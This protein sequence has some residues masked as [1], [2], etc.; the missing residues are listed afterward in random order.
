MRPFGYKGEPLTCLWCGRRFVE[1]HESILVYP[2]TVARVVP[3]VGD[4]ADDGA[5]VR[6][7]VPLVRTGRGV[8]HAQPGEVV[9]QYRVYFDPPRYKAVWRG[10][11]DTPLFDTNQCAARFGRAQAVLGHRLERK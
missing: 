2:G 1:D 11:D 4:A 3:A 8:R 7:V 9:D 6:L 5:R 10:T